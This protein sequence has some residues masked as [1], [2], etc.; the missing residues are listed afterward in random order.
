MP[1]P[2][3]VS[4]VTDWF[5]RSRTAS[6]QLFGPL[7]PDTVVLA[8]TASRCVLGFMNGMED[9]IRSADVRSR[10]GENTPA[11]FSRVR[12]IMQTPGTAGMARTLARSPRKRLF[13]LQIAR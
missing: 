10:G 7:D 4:T 12:G 1:G 2:G 9:H 6:R 11:G 5:I 8:K 13:S 3:K